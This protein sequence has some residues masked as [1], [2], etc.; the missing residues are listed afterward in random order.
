MQN[1]TFML[2]HWECCAGV[3]TGCW[4]SSSRLRSI[5]GIT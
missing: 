4:H 3:F 1:A 5:S 2:F